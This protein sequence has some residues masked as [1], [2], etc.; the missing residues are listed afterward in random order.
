MS[1]MFGIPMQNIM[2]A[3]LVIMGLCLLSVVFI[4]WRNRVMFFLGLRNIP[5]R[6]AQ[7]ILIVFGLML[8]TVIIASA[9][10]I[11]DTLTYSV[12]KQAYDLAGPIDLAV[13]KGKDEGGRIIAEEGE[14]AYFDRAAYETVSGKVAGNENLDGLAPIVVDRSPVIDTTSKQS[15]PVA[16]VLGIDAAG[17]NAL[18]GVAARD[19]GP[20]IDLAALG[21]GEV[22]V[23]AA[24]ADSLA[25]RPGDQLT[26]YARNEPRTFTVGRI[27]RDGGLGGFS[28][29]VKGAIVLPA[30]AA[31]TLFGQEDRYNGIVV[32]AKGDV[33]GGLRNEPA[34][35]DALEAA[36]AG[37][38]L[39]VDPV[40]RTALDEAELIGNVFTTFFLVFGL[41]AIAAGVMLIFLIFVMLA[42]E[43]RGEMGM[44]RAVGTKRRGLI[45]SF[46]AE[47]A[48]YDLAAAGVGALL[49]VGV[50]FGITAAMGRIFSAWD[51]APAITPHIEPR[52][53]A[54]AYS[55]GVVV[56]FLTIAV[57]SWRVSRLNIVAAI[58]DL[59]D[60]KR[61]GG[62]WKGLALGLLGV[63]LG[64]FMAANAGTK[65]APFMGGVS[66][67]ILASTLILHRLRLPQRLI[68]TLA[69]AAL[70]LFWGLPAK[71]FERI[72]G[73]YEG[74]IE[75]FFISGIMMIAGA[76]LL[77]VNN[78]ELIL[79][80]T[81]AVA[82]FARR[83]VP[84]LRMG[85]AYPMA[86]RFRTGLTLYMF[87]LIIFV[88]VVMAGIQT[89]VDKIYNDPAKQTGGWDVTGQVLPTNPVPGGGLRGALAA[90]GVAVSDI[91][92]IG[93][94]AHL[95]AEET[96]VRTLAGQRPASGYA[97]NRVD[98]GWLASTGYHLSHRAEGYAD[99]AAVWAALRGD[100]NLVVIDIYG[101]PGNDADGDDS[102]GKWKVEGITASKATFAPVQVELRSAATGKA[103]TVTII[104]VTDT[105]IWPSV[106][107]YVNG[108]AFDDL[109]G[110]RPVTDY[111]F[112]LKDGVDDRAMA[113]SI[114]AAL[115]AHGMQAESIHERV[116]RENG[117]SAGFF[118]L[119]K[120]FIGLGLVVG[121]AALGVVAFRSVVERRQQIGMLRAIGFGR[122]M[123]SAAFL[124]ESLFIT[125][126]GIVAGVTMGIILS[127]NLFNGGGFSN[128][129]ASGFII[130]WGQVALFSGI[131][132]VA[133][134]LMTIIPSRQAGN[135]E[136]AEA[137][138]YE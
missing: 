18:G 9:L 89:N 6:K 129:E 76:V 8:A 127:Y 102:I 24:L 15:E 73:K 79:A 14:A 55:L 116:A 28:S 111:L 97:V 38:G 10:T 36:T 123:V 80:G 31:Q 125:G 16:W 78:S 96:Q 87:A 138:R 81:N 46:V 32:S 26:L 27:A 124:V 137:L 61:P 49:G 40:K 34:A 84:A 128:G 3:L 44:A 100:P 48:A 82:R 130:P 51:D 12:K 117:A 99:D 113:K 2:V 115:L 135:I 22:V 134:L 90:G 72:F 106:G 64:A 52:S 77:I 65:A 114:E 112:K 92:G 122:G 86:S 13:V 136:P 30:A 53:L 108:R 19:G 126:L 1:K 7:T 47:G 91:E 107:M 109:Y 74:D 5:R 83:F 98:D 62:T 66:L 4:A 39:V 71:Q 20:A 21:D 88:L 85:T 11:G 68:Y 63:T 131:A 70:V 95:E 45:Q 59:E 23:N 118:T 110:P 42:A 41:F 56:T 119:L 58:R 43:R 94:A 101:V 50:A 93:G 105:V 25:A 69:G 104:G 133:A 29:Q 120:G 35:R 57:S 75:M 33:A 67:I 103:R 121:I 17:A 37:T 60:Q 54:V 132:L